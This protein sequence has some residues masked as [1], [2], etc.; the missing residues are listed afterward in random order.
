MWSCLPPWAFM[1]TELTQEW[2]RGVLQTRID[3]S[4]EHRAAHW[5]VR[6]PFDV[7]QPYILKVRAVTS[8]ADYDVYRHGTY[9]PPSPD[10]QKYI[11][12][13]LSNT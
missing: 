1:L 5:S 12:A 4:E 9:A 2:G 13:D 11:Y 6:G 8:A 3:R 7:Y 10:R